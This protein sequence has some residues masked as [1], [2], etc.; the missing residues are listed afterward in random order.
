[1]HSKEQIL[2]S[3]TQIFRK[4]F[5]D[6]NITLKEQTTADDIAM[7]DSLTHMTLMDT[8]EQHYKI[9]FSFDEILSFENVGDL[10]TAI[11]NKTAA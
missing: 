9:N 1:M 7:W 11:T 3:L 5:S 2:N 8:I 10:V 4:E 6:N